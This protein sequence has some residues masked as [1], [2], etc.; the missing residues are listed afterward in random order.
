[1]FVTDGS[2]GIVAVAADAPLF[3]FSAD[4]SA[5][6]ELAR[7]TKAFSARLQPP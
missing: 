4:S 6:W 5:T 3:R 2:V 1:V 7:S